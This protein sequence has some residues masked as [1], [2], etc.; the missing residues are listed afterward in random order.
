MRCR[1]KHDVSIVRPWRVNSDGQLTVSTVGTCVLEVPGCDASGATIP[2]P[3]GVNACEFF[4]QTFG[5]ALEQRSDSLLIAT[6]TG[7]QFNRR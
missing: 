5:V 6:D 2:G 1:E 4:A 3:G 7:L